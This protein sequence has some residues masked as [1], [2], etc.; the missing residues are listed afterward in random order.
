[1]V[2]VSRPPPTDCPSLWSQDP[3]LRGAQEVSETRDVSLIPER[4]PIRTIHVAFS[5]RGC[6]DPLE[7]R[8]TIGISMAFELAD[9]LM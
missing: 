7:D 1:M 2:L 9:S 8:T 5:R 4:P 3:R 6:F